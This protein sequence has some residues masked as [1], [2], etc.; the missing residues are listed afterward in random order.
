MAEEDCKDNLFCKTMQSFSRCLSALA[1]EKW[2][3]LE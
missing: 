3:F 1:M 2:Q